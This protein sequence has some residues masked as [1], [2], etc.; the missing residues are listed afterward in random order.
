MPNFIYKAKHGPGQIIEGIIEA[1]DL[2]N[3]ASKITGL[4]YSPLEV[5]LDKSKKLITKRKLSASILLFSRRISP[6]QIT[7]FTRQ[8]YDLIDANIPLL[9][10]IGLVLNQTQH[11]SLKNIVSKLYDSVKDGTTFSQALS[12]YQHI[13]SA[14]YVNMIKAGEVSGKLNESLNRLAEFTEKDQE[15]RTRVNASLLYPGLIC[16]AGVITIF[17]LMAFV[18]PRLSLMFEDLNETLP[19]ITTLLIAASNFLFQFWWIILFIIGAASLYLMK[20]KNTPEGNRLFHIFILK[21]PVIGD[22]IKNVETA[23]FARTLGT[24]LENGI[25]IVSALESVC[26]VLNNEVIKQDIVKVTADVKGGES[27]VKSIQQCRFLPQATVQMIAVGEETGSMQRSLHKLADSYERKSEA[28]I[29][30]LTS[31]LEPILILCIGS[32]IGF[33]VI[34]MLL[35]LFQMNLIIQ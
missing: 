11:A 18:I 13:F 24:L 26:G 25:T 3:A 4:G 23:R 12:Q 15:I 9:K 16:L 34:A 19:L 14:F 31:L 7:L 35:P 2:D 29:K 27:L 6:A 17:V 32:V 21:I 5:S 8:M 33:I 1:S 20:W 28:T 22:F 30:T 10:A